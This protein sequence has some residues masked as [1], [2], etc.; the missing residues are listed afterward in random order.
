VGRGNFQGF[1]E[2]WFS[3]FERTTFSLDLV[4]FV[5]YWEGWF[6]PQIYEFDKVT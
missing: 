5:S 2:V 6:F 1:V 3:G 4:I